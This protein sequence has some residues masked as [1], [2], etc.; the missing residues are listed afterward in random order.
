MGAGKCRW[1]VPA[2]KCYGHTKTGTSS[3]PKDKKLSTISV[4]QVN[5]DIKRVVVLPVV[6][7]EVA[8]LVC[9]GTAARTVII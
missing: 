4:H 5:E 7:Q 6:K 9:A 3:M 1:K 8:T 2:G